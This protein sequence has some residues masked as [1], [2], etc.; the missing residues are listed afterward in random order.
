M[1]RDQLSNIRPCDL[2]VTGVT[3]AVRATE[4]ASRLLAGGDITMPDGV[5]LDT[6]DSIVPN[7]TVL[8]QGYN[9]V[10]FK[11]VTGRQH[12]SCS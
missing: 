7:D 9:N 6:K 4:Q 11:T 5:I 3:G 2:V 8:D 12:V 1:D 10:Q